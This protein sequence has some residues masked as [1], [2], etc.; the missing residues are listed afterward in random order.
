MKNFLMSAFFLFVVSISYGQV[1]SYTIDA[2]KTYDDGTRTSY[3]TLEADLEADLIKVIE[4]ELG[5]HPDIMKFSFFDKSDYRKCMFESSAKITEEM[6]IEM[7]NDVI[8]NYTPH[9]PKEREFSKSES[10]DSFKYVYFE[11]AG[12]MKES[13]IK[14]FVE[15]LVHDKQIM[16]VERF[17][18]GAYKI[19]AFPDLTAD[20]VNNLLA[21]YNA[22]IAEE[23]IK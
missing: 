2:S 8:D 6:V 20:Y 16:S 4:I 13:E 21:K 1:K 17:D 23:Y 15:V 19:K 7:F 22:K 14:E 12:A 9:T 11:V 10:G 3:L 5:N 18:D